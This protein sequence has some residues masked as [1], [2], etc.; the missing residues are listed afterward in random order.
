MRFQ[1]KEEVFINSDDE[2]LGTAFQMKASA[3]AFRATIDS[4]Y[5]YKE[6]AMVRELISNGDDAHTLRER[7]RPDTNVMIPTHYSSVSTNQLFETTQ[8]TEENRWMAPY[9]KPYRVHVPTEKE[10]YFEIEDFGVGL[11][12]S[13]I[14]GEPIKEIVTVK[15][16][17]D[18]FMV[19][20]PTGEEHYK[21]GA[22]GKV[23]FSGG[24]YTTIFDSRKNND[25]DQIGGFGL[26][27]KSPATVSDSYTVTT[28]F[29]GEK[30]VVY[31]Y[32]DKKGMPRAELVTADDQGFPAPV[33]MQEGEY[34]GMTVN[35]PITH[36]KR[37]KVKAACRKVLRFMRNSYVLNIGI[38]V[39]QPNWI[40]HKFANM[41]ISD[42]KNGNHYVIMGGVTYPME[43]DILPQDLQGKLENIKTDTYLFL[44]VGAVTP[45]PSREDLEY[46]DHNIE[47]LEIEYS[48]AL[49]KVDEYVKSYRTPADVVARINMYNNLNTIFKG[50]YLNSVLPPVLRYPKGDNSDLVEMGVTRHLG[51]D[52]PKGYR[53][54]R[55]VGY[56][57][58][59]SVGAMLES[60]DITSLKRGIRSGMDSVDVY[61]KKD[62]RK[63]MFFYIPS[64]CLAPYVKLA[65]FANGLDRNEYVRVVPINMEYNSRTRFIKMLADKEFDYRTHIEQ[66]KQDLVSLNANSIYLN[67]K[68][69][70]GVL[71]TV[72]T[73]TNIQS[74]AESV[75]VRYYAETVGFMD[76][77][78]F[79]E[80]CFGQLGAEIVNA[81]DIKIERRKAKALEARGVM[82]LR[83]NY[84]GSKKRV[85]LDSLGESFQELVDVC[86]KVGSKIPY[87]LLSGSD[88][89]VADPLSSDY[90]LF[91]IVDEIHDLYK[92]AETHSEL[93][94]KINDTP[95]FN[96]R[97]L[98]V[99][100]RKNARSLLKDFSD[101]FITAEEYQDELI[102]ACV[103]KG[104][105][106]DYCQSLRLIDISNLELKRYWE[107]YI[108]LKVTA[109]RLLTDAMTP[110]KQM[111]SYRLRE[112][113]RKAKKFID[114]IEDLPSYLSDI[115]END[116]AV[117]NAR[118]K[119]K[120]FTDY[121]KNKLEELDTWARELTGVGFQRLTRYGSDTLH[122][123]YELMF[124]YKMAG[125]TKG[126]IS[127]C[128]EKERNLERHQNRLKTDISRV[129]ISSSMSVLSS[130]RRHSKY[131]TSEKKLSILPRSVIIQLRLQQLGVLPEEYHTDMS[132]FYTKEGMKEYL[133]DI[134]EKGK[135][136]E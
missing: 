48:M 95:D 25:N 122:E 8:N 61:P 64:G 60:N 82:R 40:G 102:Q 50:H 33:P 11:P 134:K 67:T 72:T 42:Q 52:L 18:G 63:T 114:D 107:S 91:K 109:P 123:Y 94:N 6:E 108:H 133:E 75:L 46:T 80:I 39:S 27:C 118:V 104:V 66:C 9:G 56:G 26:G 20:V 116:K 15:K 54:I 30:H 126:F 28:R 41:R 51:Y 125:V 21:F 53:S 97:P 129:Y 110:L 89:D 57:Y 62:G 136:N 130:I 73:D 36:D 78:K 71:S 47:V 121:W 10:P 19:D 93:F 24:M 112:G 83:N 5:R 105:V 120:R 131:Q 13:D 76:D 128:W 68:N 16:E 113:D 55:V 45:Q 12:L 44:D 34:N 79:L 99:G 4:L 84:Y 1:E 35:V 111:Y 119:T 101:V 3:E 32:I 65:Q 23:M 132:K 17:V 7:E 115:L 49:E 86:R 87:V 69:N 14:I 74:T 100:L 43:L 81:N 77:F 124:V 127:S 37:H 98:L 85:K 22:N 58:S 38:G 59:V 103:S 92:F 31:M 70:A 90:S 135:D 88:F 117:I 106:E 96:N 29:N 2:L